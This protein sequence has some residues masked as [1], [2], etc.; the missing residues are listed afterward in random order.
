[1]VSHDLLFV[2]LFLDPRVLFEVDGEGI[3][4]ISQRVLGLVRGK[5][6]AGLGIPVE[7]AKVIIHHQRE[8]EVAELEGAIGDV[9]KFDIPEKRVALSAAILHG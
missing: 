5:R 8:S 7:F 9:V 1:M 6:L 3:G 2:V 4:R